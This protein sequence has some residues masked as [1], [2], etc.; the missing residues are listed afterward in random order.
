MVP[1]TLLASK[2]H[3]L[4]RG[5]S[6]TCGRHN[7]SLE[8]GLQVFHRDIFPGP[9]S[10]K[11]TQDHLIDDIASKVTRRDRSLLTGFI[12]LLR[13][14]VDNLTRK[15]LHWKNGSSGASS[16]RSCH[17]AQV[18][19]EEPLPCSLMTNTETAGSPEVW[20]SRLPCV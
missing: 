20:F 18:S 7:L 15:P 10:L 16:R 5:E 9:S 11:Q 6:V 3:I 8:A 12:F 19:T 13:F 4:T 17:N 1:S 2:A 14:H